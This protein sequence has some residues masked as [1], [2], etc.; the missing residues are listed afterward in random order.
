MN[1]VSCSQKEGKR[2]NEKNRGLKREGGVEA[3]TTVKG[4]MR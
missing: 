2:V 1:R 4:S 3:I